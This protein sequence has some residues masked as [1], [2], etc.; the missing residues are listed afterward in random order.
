MTRKQLAAALGKLGKGRRKTMTDAAK[1]QRIAASKASVLAR[2][3]IS[4]NNP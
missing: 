3:K 2:R 4:E 1:A